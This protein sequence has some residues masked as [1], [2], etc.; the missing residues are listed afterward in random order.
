MFE[1]PDNLDSLSNADLQA[2]IDQAL[3]AFQ[4]LGLSADSSDE[5]IANGES[6]ANGIKALREQVVANDTAAQE[7]AAKVNDLL[8]S[9]AVDEPG[10]EP[11]E[12]EKAEAAPDP[13][14]VAEPI[15]ASAKPAPK[16]R[17]VQRAAANAPRVSVP[18]KPTVSVLAAADVPGF[19]TGQ[20]LGD[21]GKAAEAVLNRM[22]AL[23]SH[24]IPN[25]RMQFG[26]AAIRRSGFGD[27]VQGTDDD[28]NLINRAGDEK[29]LQGNSLVA[30]G[31]WCAPSETLYDLCQTETLDGL[32]SLPEVQVT[33]G[34]V[35]YSPGPDF[36]DIYN[37]PTGFWDFS[38]AEAIAGTGDKTCY[39]VT[40]PPFTDVRLDAYGLCVK[41]PI[42]TNAGYPELVR[43]IIE[44]SLV[45]HQ[46]KVNA[47]VISIME[48]IAGAGITVPNQGTLAFN[49]DHLEWQAQAIREGYQLADGASVEAILPTF[50]RPLIRA[51]FGRRQG[52]DFNAISDA[53]I[54]SWFSSRNIAVQFVRD[55]QPL[56][57]GHGLQAVPANI[58]ALLYPAGTWIKGVQ[59]VINLDTVYDSTGLLENT[60]TGLFVE[61]GGLVVQRCTGTT[62]ITIP[63]CVSGKTAAAILDECMGTAAA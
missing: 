14:P 28:Y 36:S 21:L 8:S 26:A 32:L 61:E 39:E 7:R 52:A 5:D 25:T 42:L 48:A 2:Q 20:D 22:R 58:K 1:L 24:H 4:A 3:E 54:D 29:R 16:Q 34:G 33:R 31:G 63:V 13:E 9:V 10:D 62:K 46:H 51:E 18:A 11:V 27:L 47:R 55:W 38:E 53:Q 15:A 60:Y 43:R 17:P 45:A 19:S 30:A 6:L 40:C 59:D 57:A 12:D 35:R 44:G 49:L 41:V 37:S 50:A 23:P 56:T